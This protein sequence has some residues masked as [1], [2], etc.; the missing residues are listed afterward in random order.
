[1]KINDTISRRKISWKKIAIFFTEIDNS[2]SVGEHAHTVRYKAALKKLSDK[3]VSRKTT[4]L[5][6]NIAAKLSSVNN[7]VENWS[8]I[9]SGF[10]VFQL[11]KASLERHPVNSGTV[12]N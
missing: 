2:R 1:M 6:K 7:F 3:I 8:E 12:I 4:P 5:W 11:T 10:V 9:R